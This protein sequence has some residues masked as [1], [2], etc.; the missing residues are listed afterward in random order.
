MYM[1]NLCKVVLLVVESCEVLLFYFMLYEG[2]EFLYYCVYM[3]VVLNQNLVQ[4][5]WYLLCYYG[6]WVFFIGNNYVFVYELNCIMCDLFEQ[7]QGQVVDEVYLFFYVL[8]EVFVIVMVWIE[9]LCL[10]V[11]YLIVV[12]SDM[13]WL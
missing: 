13:I 6:K 8:D 4:L 3:G 11:I 9:M 12:G 2:F 5:V 1:L 10:D 7:V